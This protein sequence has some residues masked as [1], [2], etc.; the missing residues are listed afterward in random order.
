MPGSL[1]EIKKKIKATKNTRKI[2]KAMQLVAASKMRVFQKKAVH[3]REFAWD[4]LEVLRNNL[5]EQVQTSLME[6]RETGKTVFVLYTSDKGLCG[7]LNTR[8]LKTLM[9]SSKWNNTPESERLLFTVGKKS[10]DY[11]T[12]RSIPVEKSFNSINEK[13]TAHDA[14]K[15]VSDIINYWNH[16]KVK[17]VVMIAPHYKNSLIYYPV[18][19]TYL[20]FSA[21]MVHQHV[22]AAL[23]AE[24]EHTNTEEVFTN[25]PFIEYE[26]SQEHFTQVLV[27]QIVTTLFMQSFLEL[28]ASEYS[29]R[30]IAMQNAT[31]AAGD[32]IHKYSLQY[33]KARQAAITQEI[34]E[35]VSGSMA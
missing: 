25:E 26:P 35:I 31:D 10:Y 17:E 2:T 12:F 14:L 24:G 33:N 27:E 13:I 5:D 30:M 1:N 6:R 7:A 18:M 20:P 21:D 23:E 16:H 15:I 8:I 4:M 11:A 22:H 9:T 34:A 32:M 3:S 19:K 29:S 28:K